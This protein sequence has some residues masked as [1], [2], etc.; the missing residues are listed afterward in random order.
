MSSNRLCVNPNKTELIWLSS[1]RR[2]HLYPTNPVPLSGSWIAPAKNVR[3][4][5]VILDNGL[6]MIPRVNKLI[7]M[8]Y[9]NIRQ[10]RTVR[11]SLTTES[12]HS[13]VRALI[14]SRLDYCNGILSGLP[15]YMIERLQSVLKASA[16]LVLKKPPRASVSAAMTS[17]SLHWLP[18]PQ[19]I[20]FKT[21]VL[22]YKCLHDLAPPYLA[23]RFTSVSDIPGRS[24]LRS[25]T[26]VR[27]QLILPR[28]KTITIGQRGFYFAGPHSW[29]SLPIELYATIVYHCQL[30]GNF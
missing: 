27:Q 4:L 26:F 12:T 16:R 9:F 18:F 13:L 1:P 10:L 24:M 5:G 14:H 20:T 25:N 6:T 28:T 29:N 8:C 19:R 23:R 21:A 15:A 22:T 7:S 17:C 30:S 3:N 2:V 11:R